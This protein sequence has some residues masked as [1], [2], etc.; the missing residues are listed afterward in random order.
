MS[1]LKTT[2][3]RVVFLEGSEDT[4]PDK[5]YQK[6]MEEASIEECAL[7]LPK[8]YLS[9]SQLLQYQ[10][11]P[12]QYYFRTVKGVVMP[13]SIAMAEGKAVHRSLEVGH[14]EAVK[15]GNVS[16]DLMLDAY[17]DTW[18]N[19][20]SDIDWSIGNEDDAS[21]DQIQ[22]RDHALLAIYQRFHL[23]VLKAIIDPMGPFIERRFWVTIGEMRIPLLGYIDLLA[24]E[25][26]DGP[27]SGTTMADPPILIDHKVVS[28][29]KSA[30]DAQNDTQLTIYSMVAKVSQVAFNCLTS[31]KVPVVKMVRASRSM[32]DWHWAQFV[33]QQVA[34]SIAKGSFP[35]GAPSWWCSKKWCGWYD[36]CHTGQ[37]P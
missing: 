13:P 14:W 34:E 22:K 36:M 33:I 18:K 15:S 30:S 29:T 28:R 3:S 11:C 37:P 12:R 7:E 10:R 31:T 26:T 25:R 24:E 21:E 6:M 16:L 35:P 27:T 8:G 5:E 2:E 17:T 4:D 20:R 1:G 19:I 23:P 32:S 9:V